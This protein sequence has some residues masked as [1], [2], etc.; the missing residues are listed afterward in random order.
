M[1][2]ISKMIGDPGPLGA[3][4]ALTRFGGVALLVAIG[5][6]HLLDISH[7]IEEGVWYMAFLFVTLVVLCVA[8]SVALIRADDSR[9]R[10]AWVAAA[11]LA[12]GTMFGYCVSRAIPLPGMGDHQGDWASTIGIA[13]WL[14]E[15]G[16][17]GLSGFALRDRVLRR[18]AE[19]RPRRHRARFAAPVLGL[20][21]MLAMQPTFAAAHGGEEMTPEE[22]TATEQ[23]AIEMGHDPATMN[24]GAAA[25][26]PLLGD[27]ELG[28][29]LVLAVGFVGWAGLALKRRIPIA[30]RESSAARLSHSFG[31]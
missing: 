5:Y 26:D 8:C 24:H 29:I 4:E 30:G 18:Q 31:R 3:R 10:F 20:V 21:A 16:L 12:I 22:M 2:S 7:K 25:H 17:I 23:A 15:L 14:F 6:V 27:T 11:G 9:V 28:I 13:A 19:S 1:Q